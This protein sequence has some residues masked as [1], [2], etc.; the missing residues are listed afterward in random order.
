MP[1]SLAKD[2]FVK[3]N[4]LIEKNSNS[5]KNIGTIVAIRGVVVDVLFKVSVPA[6]KNALIIEAD[7]K[8]IYLEVFSHLGNGVIRAISMSDTMGLKRGIKV[9]DLKEGISV[10]V[11]SNTLGRVL[12]V[13]G[14]PIDGRGPVEGYKQEIHKAPPKF[15]DQ[16]IKSEILITGI[17]VIDLLA[18]YVKGG[19]IGLFGGAGVGKTVLIMELINNM[20]QEHGGRAVFTGVGERIRE[21]HELYNEMIR[22]NLIDLEG[23][24]SKVCLMYGQ[25]NEPPGA[26]ARVALSGVTV[27][28][29]FRDVENQDVFLFIDN[30]FRFSQAGAEL[31]ILLERL[32]SAVGYQPTLD[33]EMGILQERITSTKKNSITSIQAIYLPADDTTD[34][35]PASAFSHLDAITV[36]D[37]S[38][39]AKGIFPAI[40]PLSS[41]S[42]TLIPEIVGDE[43]YDIATRVLICLQKYDE[44]K[45]TIAALGMDELSEEDKSTVLKARKIQ[46]FFSQPM[47]MAQSFSSTPGKY[48]E[49]EETIEGCKKI[50]DGELDHLPD[51]AFYMVGNIHE[52]IEKARRL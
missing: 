52:A 48:V 8:K 5:E 39:A 29:H 14:D 2:D 15:E 23:G 37:R 7:S 24:M 50:L 38:I 44:L 17:K 30:L 22:E 20:A 49:L 11:G 13:V 36:L 47:F 19:K 1:D 3:K 46:N 6:I 9:I 26:R 16:S 27:A 34:P 45:D 51:S 41:S 32:P 40:N 4:E 43:H 18:P 42:N 33:A 31:S 35:A 10:P 25:M 21:G 12:N 28:E